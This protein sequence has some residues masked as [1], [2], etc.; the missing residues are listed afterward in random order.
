MDNNFLLRKA[1][2][3]DLKRINE[4]YNWAVLNTVA[5][6]DL[7]ERSFESAEKWFNIHQ[8]PYYPVYVIEAQ[9]EVRGWGSISPFHPRPAYKKS[10]EFSIYIDPDWTGKSMG[11]ALLKYICQEA[12]VLGYHTLLGLIT[13]SNEKSLSLARKHHFI[14]TGRYK[15]VGMKFG[16]YLDVIVVQRIFT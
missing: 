9:G 1:I 13:A 3:G 12:A 4:I 16:Q 8:D 11:D 6:F 2:Y 5:T 10:G 7:E 15:E 14:E